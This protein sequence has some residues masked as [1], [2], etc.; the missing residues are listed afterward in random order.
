MSRPRRNLRVDLLAAAAPQSDGNMASYQ[1]EADRRTQSDHVI[2]QVP[3]V[4]IDRSP[5]QHRI[6]FDGDQLVQLAESIG[7]DGSGLLQPPTVRRMPNGRY[8]LVAGERRV[9]AARL[10]GLPTLRVQIRQMTD[11]EAL[12]AA[13]RE[14]IDRATL[15]PWETCMAYLAIRELARKRVRNNAGA[16]VVAGMSG[17]HQRSVV[18]NYLEAGEAVPLSMLLRAG[19]GTGQGDHVDPTV[20]RALTLTDLLSVAARPTEDE[21]LERLTMLVQAIRGSGRTAPAEDGKSAGDADEVER[22]AAGRS[23]PSGSRHRRAPR[24]REGGDH[25]YD[26]LMR[27]GGF[28]KCIR[29]PIERM[30]VAEARKH[31]D[32]L[33][34]AVAAL[35]TRAI[36]DDA[37]PVVHL[38]AEGAPVTVLAIRADDGRWLAALQGWMSNVA[39]ETGSSGHGA[40]TDS[41]PEF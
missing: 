10:N 37:G 39:G 17:K 8:Q 15:L 1:P 14:N 19:A 21:R 35:A 26:S 16:G 18:A 41:Q 30:R 34:P 20:L 33:T 5:Y 31:L 38:Q 13:C 22:G 27:Q 3:L 12:E 28:Q 40:A 6:D 9:R 29:A 11:E 7:R 36:A 4:L 2:E 23:R 25:T 24:M 32:S